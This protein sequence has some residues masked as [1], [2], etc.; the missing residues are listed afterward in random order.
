M[1]GGAEDM[2]GLTVVAL[3]LD[4]LGSGKILFKAQDI[5]DL[6]AFANGRGRDLYFAYQARLTTLKACDF[7]DLL[8]HP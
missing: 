5:V 2:F 4:D 6:R 7:G 3:K 1:G 8:M